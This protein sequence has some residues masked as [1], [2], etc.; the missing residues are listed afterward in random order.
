MD[1]WTDATFVP[2]AKRK[3]GLL[4]SDDL[5]LPSGVGTVSK[6]IITKTI[7]HFNWVQVGGAIKHP[8]QGKIVDMSKEM[9]RV[10]GVGENYMRIYP[11]SGYGDPDLVRELINREN[12]DFI[13]HFT[14]PRFWIWLYQMEHEIRQYTPLL[15]YHI[16]DDLP[17]PQ[18]NEDYYESCDSLACISKQTYNIVK[19]VRKRLPIEPWALKYVPHGIDY[20][21][22]HPVTIDNPGKVVETKVKQPDGKEVVKK[23]TEFEEMLDFRQKVTKGK[24]FDFLIFYN[25]RNIRRKSP[26]DVIL[27]FQKFWEMLDE[28][29]RERVGLVMHT[30]IVDN[31]GTDLMAVKQAIAPDTH[32]IFSNE[33]LDP[34]YINYL[35]NIVDVTINMASNEGFGLATCESVMAGTPII[36]NV[37]GGLQDQMGFV[38]KNGN[39]LDPD[40]HF[41]AK[42]GSNHDG[43]YKKHG[44]WVQPL[45]PTNRSLVGSPP[46]P[47]IFDDRCDW[48]DAAHAMKYWYDLGEEGRRKAGEAGIKYLKD[49]NVGM[50]AQNMGLR[51]IDYINTTLEKWTPRKRFSVFEV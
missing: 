50:T 19:Q 20:T 40:K 42:W 31:N 49:E 23:W 43:K 24:E 13:M 8:D 7:H 37:T 21:V 27:G 4:L 3:K 17:F 9:N 41:G 28:D 34:R 36:A 29:Q 6:E 44:E 45:F 11:V 30:A 12:P 38:D 15:F 47:Y 35:Y 18:Y 16:W 25:N 33:K 26:G 32:I 46:T 2:F 48:M 5:R 51:F 14:D 1:K 10:T 22:Y 39:Y